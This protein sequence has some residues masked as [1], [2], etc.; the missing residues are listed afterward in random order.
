MIYALKRI[1]DHH[2]HVRDRNESDPRREF[3]S[4]RLKEHHR[5]NQGD[6]KRTDHRLTFFVVSRKGRQDHHARGDKQG[7]QH[8]AD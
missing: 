2:H 5:H 4:V 1:A 7:Q 6:V 8:G 3:Q